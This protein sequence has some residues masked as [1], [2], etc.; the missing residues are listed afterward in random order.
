M[1]MK[2]SCRLESSTYSTEVLFLRDRNQ[3]YSREE[4]QGRGGDKLIKARF[5]APPKSMGAVRFTVPQVSPRMR[6]AVER[7]RYISS[8]RTSPGPCQPDLNS[9]IAFWSK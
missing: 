2:K 4:E 6:L 3:D 5:A 7:H 8:Q 1:T 9:R